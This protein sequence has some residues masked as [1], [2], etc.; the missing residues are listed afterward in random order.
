LVKE[1]SSPDVF[2]AY[3]DTK[4]HIVSPDQMTEL[5]LLWDAVEVQ[6]DH[7]LDNLKRV[8][9]CQ[10]PTVK[11][12]QVFPVQTTNPYVPG[13]KPISSI[14][15]NNVLV[16]GFLTDAENWNANHNA[17]VEDLL[18]YLV[19]DVRFIDALYGP[20]GLSNALRTAKLP[21]FLD[22]GDTRPVPDLPFGDLPEDANH[23]MCAT[24]GAFILP[25]RVN[26]D[27]YTEGSG[28]CFPTLH[29][30]L[31]CWHVTEIVGDMRDVLPYHTVALGTA[32]QGWVNVPYQGKVYNGASDCWWPF[33]PYNPDGGTHAL[34]KFDNVLVCGTLFQ[35]IAHDVGAGDGPGT[36]WNT[37]WAGDGGW[38]EIHP[39]DWMWRYQ[40]P[41]P[42]RTVHSTA[43]STAAQSTKNSDGGTMNPLS[44]NGAPV[45][46]RQTPAGPPREVVDL[47]FSKAQEF[48]AHAVELGAGGMPQLNV[49][50]EATGPRFFKAAYY[51]DWSLF[52][53]GNDAVFV[54]QSVPA[55]VGPGATASITVR[56]T[57]TTTWSPGANY[58]LGSQSP[59]DNTVWGTNRVQLTGP[60][61]PGQLATF[62]LSLAQPPAAGATFQWQMVQENVQWFGMKTPAIQL[63]GE[64]ATLAAEVRSEKNVI[65]S[66]QA[67]LHQA[68]AG[69]R[70][71]IIQQI[72]AAEKKL[73]SL[74]QAQKALGCPGAP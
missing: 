30:E 69:E 40:P 29:M 1:T 62:T 13:Q 27:Q 33:N 63:G 35:D 46:T 55:I 39:I 9:M 8:E 12:S 49:A 17:G 2:L 5:G 38:L 67:E 45:A 60:V 26:G 48:T 4:F 66:L 72:V 16:S 11:P 50:L 6:A 23:E 43:M 10:G 56:N 57:G 54:T 21:G 65:A 74:Q 37:Q 44:W 64:C 34:Q 28:L 14:V 7:S 20:N 31:N 53:E 36:A 51:V 3:G 42:T 61:A 58:R 70:P 73:A 15:R 25:S 59:Q 24:A 68:S 71:A 18:Y 41:P 19:L 47:R 22:P 32:P 52:S